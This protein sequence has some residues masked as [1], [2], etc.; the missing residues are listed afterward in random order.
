MRL[1]LS[2]ALRLPWGLLLLLAW[3]KSQGI[4]PYE[5]GRGK[6]FTLVTSRDTDEGAIRADEIKE[7][8]EKLFPESI[9]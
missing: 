7:L 3:Y 1:R 2:E 6:E 8:I 4:V 5:E 9:K